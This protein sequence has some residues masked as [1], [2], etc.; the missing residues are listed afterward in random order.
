MPARIKKSQPRSDY[1][2]DEILCYAGIKFSKEYYF[3]KQMKSKTGRPRMWRFDYVILPLELKIAIEVD[4]GNYSFGRHT[5][6]AGFEGDCQKF[7]AAVNLGWRVFHYTPNMLRQSQQQVIDD[8]R[9]I[10]K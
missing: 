3:A 2:M 5:R 4:G 9:G 1:T 6:G 10:I 7:N 8:I